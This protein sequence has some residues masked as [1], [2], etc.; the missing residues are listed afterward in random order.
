M[1]MF[2][3]SVMVKGSRVKVLHTSCLLVFFL[4]QTIASTSWQDETLVVMGFLNHY[5]GFSILPKMQRD[6]VREKKFLLH[7]LSCF[8]L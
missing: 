7:L 1:G 6:L 4:F 8:S 5:I 2:C 3:I